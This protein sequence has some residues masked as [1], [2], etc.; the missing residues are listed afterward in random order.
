MLG[1]RILLLITA[2][3]VCL[4][5]SA[6][7]VAIL[8][9]R[10]LACHGP[11]TRMGGLDL[12]TR[13]SALRGGSRGPAIGTADLSGGWLIRRIRANEMPPNAPLARSERE[14]LEAWV[15][16][17]AEWSS[18]LQQRRAGKDWWSLQPIRVRLPAPAP[19][20]WNHSTIDRWVHSRLAKEGLTPNP[21]ASRR[22]MIRR[23]SFDLTGLPPEPGEISAFESDPRPDAY[24]RLV[25][26]LLASP[27]FG[28]R[29]GRHWL[30]VVRFAESEGFERDE[31]REF[32]W[33]FRDYVIRSFNADKS[34]R[35][36]ARE[37]IAGDL[38]EP[39][40]HDGIVAT[41][42][43]ALGPL[44]AVG[45]T[46]AIPQERASIRED[47]LEEMIGVVSQTFLGLTANCARCHDHK[48]DPIPQRD[49]YRFKAAFEGVWQPT[50]DKSVAGLDELFPH[51]RPL[52]TPGERDTRVRRIASIEEKIAALEVRI[53][54]ETRKRAPRREPAG[55]PRPISLWRLDN[56]ARDE[57]GP[58]HGIGPPAS[59]R[60]VIAT[61][62][63]PVTIR[64]KTLAAWV[65]FVKMPG[66]ALTVFELR[67]ISGYRG[68]SLDG[69]HYTGNT[70]SWENASVGRFRTQ[71]WKNEP[72]TGGLVH[73]VIA[74]D[75]DGRIR[76]YRNGRPYGKPY[77]PDPSTPAGRLQT[78][79]AGDAV[80]KLS[81][82]R[83]AVLEE[84]SL[85]HRSLNEEEVGRLF[86]AGVEIYEPSENTRLATGPLESELLRLRAALASVPS[87]PLVFAAT[88]KPADPTRVLARGD[89]NRPGEIVAPGGFSCLNGGDTG[90]RRE[91]AEWIASD[92][93]PLF[94]RTIVNRVWHYHFGTGLAESPNDLGYNG[95][96]A[97][98]PELLDALAAGLISRG[99]SL[100]N[101]HREIVMSQAYR[102]ASSYRAEAAAK[103]SGS[104]L[105]WRFPPQRLEAEAVR[106]A[107]LAAS[108]LLNHK[109][110]G[111]GF[112]PFEL[113]KT[114][115]YQN[116]KPVESGD[117][118]HQRRTIYRM[119]VNTGG[120]PMLEALDCPMP[121]MKAPRRPVTTT[122]L[123]A[124]SLMNNDF[125][126]LQAKA[127]AARLRR[128]SEG[129]GR[130]TLGFLL[131]L[132]RTPDSVEL[133]WSR[134]LVRQYGL[135]HFCW[136]LFNTSEFLYAR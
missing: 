9:K 89:V 40:T 39:F 135:E 99:W 14:T 127:F 22:T 76:M 80:A 67:N 85:F 46:S 134:D 87:P 77:V 133:S 42:M 31:M 23:L 120:H 33:P 25:D 27:H 105:L 79:Y 44:D 88:V 30:D 36:F 49:Y 101:L 129:D 96:L 57:F 4:A 35:T 91:L 114:G 37:Q 65:R 19:G 20:D 103:D 58:M 78:Y 28:E 136:G 97:S 106:D 16:A 29:W 55:V 34:Y 117:P 82:S 48:F 43:L 110:G 3:P 92:S 104:R 38:I 69:I 74:Y 124:L 26:R 75:T 113:T 45:L 24:E 107:M 126:Q 17:G 125:V 123:Q 41:A 81:T 71:E 60:G 13:E 8:E 115:S 122:A 1:R 118:E 54:A 131:A 84:A 121:I 132:G 21:P 6:E 32:A 11:Q 64:A 62:K 15:A 108:G 95:G 18:T 100:K 98:H 56:D 5:Q 53:G 86:A 47:Q 12:S 109:M 130:L 66:R 112:R 72:E 52:E 102:Q 10:C 61:A 2:A 7:A 59:G 73:I 63:L 90:G 68:A 116:Y 119:N 93:N 83:E 51:G 70:K 94:A 111:P 50:L 128:E